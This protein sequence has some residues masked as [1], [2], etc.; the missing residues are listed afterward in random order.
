[1]TEK[2]AIV[3]A[4]NVCT[5]SNATISILNFEGYEIEEIF[6]METPP[7]VEYLAETAKMLQSDIK[8]MVRS[9]EPL[10]AQLGLSLD[11]D[12]TDEEWFEILNQNPALIQRPIVIINGKA[13]VAR[14]AEKVREIMP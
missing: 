5:K 1:M 9:E 4:N 12:K 8:D 2:K 6:Y 11:D 13:I 10:F 14:P 7:T 3:Y